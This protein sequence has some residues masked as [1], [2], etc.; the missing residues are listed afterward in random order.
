[1]VYRVKKAEF[2]GIKFKEADNASLTVW[3]DP[4]TELPVQIALRC[5]TDVEG[6][7]RDVFLWTDFRW[8]EPLDAK[9][10]RLDIPGGYEVIHAKPAPAYVLGRTEQANGQPS[11]GKQK[12]KHPIKKVDFAQVIANVNEAKSVACEAHAKMGGGGIMAEL[13]ANEDAARRNSFMIQI[14]DFKQGKAVR[15]HG[16]FSFGVLPG[17][18]RAYRWNIEK[19]QLTE[20]SRQFP[21]PAVL[22]HNM[23]S[24]H[25]EKM[26]EASID[27]RAVVGYRVKNVDVVAV[28]GEPDEA[29]DASLYVSV[30]LRTELPIEISLTCTAPGAGEIKTWFRWEKI[31]WDEPLDSDLFKLKIPDG[32][33]VIEGPPPEGS[34]W[35][36]IEKL[37]R[38]RRPPKKSRP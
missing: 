23:K 9:L 14:E 17:S 16:R 29:L 25:A 26:R 1:M 20:M 31:R 35:P 10:L 4:R 8:N 36:D 2:F 34:L 6:K 32:H 33:T 19:G 7:S 13:Y 38:G 30:D 18:D 22:F 21:N 27:G 12:P 3:V 15:Y 5:S 24:E 28:M 37:I 11:E